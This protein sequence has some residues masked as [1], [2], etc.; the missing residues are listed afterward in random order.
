MM[1]NGARRAAIEAVWRDRVGAMLTLTRGRGRHARS[2]HRADSP[3][4][5]RIA[6]PKTQQNT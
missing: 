1:K 6:V 2:N 5:D 3:T 4:R